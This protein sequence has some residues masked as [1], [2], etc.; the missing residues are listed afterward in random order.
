MPCL[1]SGQRRPEGPVQE[2]SMRTIGASIASTGIGGNRAPAYSYCVKTIPP[3]HLLRL[4]QHVTEIN[5]RLGFTFTL[6]NFVTAQMG[7][8]RLHETTTETMVSNVLGLIKQLRL[9]ARTL[10]PFLLSNP[11]FLRRSPSAVHTQFTTIAAMLGMP[12]QTYVKR[13]LKNSRIANATPDTI[14]ALIDVL[15]SEL[16]LTTTTAVAMLRSHTMLLGSS[17]TTIA[18]NIRE[19]IELLGLSKFDYARFVRRSPGLLSIPASTLQSKIIAFAALFNVHPSAALHALRRAPPLIAMATDTIEH[20]LQQAASALI[21]STDTW[22]RIVI[23]RPGLAAY[24]ADSILTTVS[25]IAALFKMPVSDVVSVAAQYPSLLCLS[26]NAFESKL[27]LILEI[28]HALGFSHTAPD[29][30]REYPLAF[31]YAPA[32][33]EERL[34]LAKLGLGPRSVMNLLTLANEDAAPLLRRSRAFAQAPT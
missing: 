21:L 14:T 3:A 34:L 33:L 29:V 20:N 1:E 25:N 19:A 11:T 26:I 5:R 10:Q 13:V 12:W 23:K 24:R 4:E 27:P 22:K 18:T 30:L 2:E 8:E 28:S 6:E 17:P 9:P 15:T 7:Y 32:R 16:P 31:T